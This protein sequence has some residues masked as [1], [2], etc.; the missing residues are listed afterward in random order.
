MYKEPMLRFYIASILLLTLWSNH[1]L[2]QGGFTASAVQ[3]TSEVKNDTQISGQVEDPTESSIQFRVIKNTISFEKEFFDVPILSDQSFEFNFKLA[4][5]TVIEMMYG[6]SSIKIYLEPKNDVYISFNGKDFINS[7]T[8]SG[9]GAVHNDYYVATQQQFSRWDRNFILYEITR[10]QA[11]DFTTYIS[12]LH[13]QR[14]EFLTT[15]PSNLKASFTEDFSDFIIADID[16]WW[17]YYLMM[18]RIERPLILGEP[19]PME[20][21]ESYYAFLDDIEISNDAALNN[22][23]YLDF[24]DEYMQFKSSQSDQ[25]LTPQAQLIAVHRS[26]EKYILTKTYQLKVRPTPYDDKTELCVLS[27]N[28]EL[29]YLRN[30]TTETFRY[31]MNGLVYIDNF[32]KVKTPNGIV[33]WVPGLGIKFK[34]REITATSNVTSI[35]KD[36][37]VRSY[38]KNE[39]LYYA[40][41]KQLYQKTNQNKLQQ[42]GRDIAI[43][44]DEN[45][46]E[47]YTKILSA[48]YEIAQLKGK[49]D[50]TFLNTYSYSNLTTPIIK[51]TS[52]GLAPKHTLSKKKNSI[53]IPRNTDYVEIDAKPKKRPTTPTSIKGN[54]IHIKDQKA[55]LVLYTDPVLFREKRFSLDG[56]FSHNIHLSE[57]TFGVINRGDEQVP[58]YIEPG[59]R[60]VIVSENHHLSK[61][62]KYS[63]R[64]SLHNTYLLDFQRHFKNLH[65][66]LEQKI[67]YA[68]PKEFLAFMNKARLKKRA[69]CQRYQKEKRLTNAFEIQMEADID[70]WY[71]FHLLN[72]T[73]ERPLYEG[74]DGRMNVPNDYYDF[75][76]DIELSPE[77]VLPNANYTYFLN[78][79]LDFQS[80]KEEHLGMTKVDLANQFLEKEAVYFVEAQEMSI[81]CKRGRSQALGHVIKAYIEQCPYE[82]YN[83]ALRFVYNESKGLISGTLA[84]D[85]ILNDIDGNKVAL[86]DLKGKVVYLDFW[87]TWCNPCVRS[88]HHSH[89]LSQ[90]FA[91]QDVVFLYVSLDEDQKK[92][93]KYLESHDVAGI[94]VHADS[95]NIYQ[96]EIAQLYKVKKLPTYVL[97]DKDGKIAYYPAN[98]PSNSQLVVQIKELIS[99]EN[100]AN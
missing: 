8:F 32:Y 80:E 92:W 24:L 91:N 67:R 11:S 57:S 59:D 100:T 26:I 37:D 4:Q 1:L 30:K 72:Y 65:Q 66:E 39:T 42:V 20:L 89:K 79:Y 58:V 15:Y 54:F 64:G 14:L 41:A 10:R 60:L 77:G 44:R 27:R 40:L 7:L 22:H 74:K 9:D 16:Y 50:D 3:I 94:H 34:E 53:H 90:T 81:A 21:P 83:D 88:L 62:L 36:T 46:F 28:T 86:S 48:A 69:Y 71:A 98:S 87:A 61:N 56:K 33:G 63:G 52:L 18:Y 93:Q 73:I 85:F 47:V 2:A 17:A 78:E 31:E 19:V 45:P 49:G 29:E 82:S 6:Q 84:P 38:L 35:E 99:R 75:L 96:S 25:Q 5:P 12:A 68:N 13:K 97:V 55:E 43:F 70:Y 51:G 95:E 76:S 23:Y